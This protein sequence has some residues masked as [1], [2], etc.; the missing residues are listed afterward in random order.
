MSLSDS[1]VG[2]ALPDSPSDAS[3][4][5]VDSPTE[6]SALEH[7]IPTRLINDN[8]DD[9][10]NNLFYKNIISLQSQQKNNGRVHEIDSDGKL[11]LKISLKGLR[12]ERNKENTNN[13][14]LNQ[15][16][17]QNND[18]ISLPS[19]TQTSTQDTNKLI[20]QNAVPPTEPLSKSSHTSIYEGNDINTAHIVPLRTNL[21]DLNDSFSDDI[22][23][24]EIENAVVTP[25]INRTLNL[26][27]NVTVSIDDNS[28]FITLKFTPQ[29]RDR[30]KLENLSLLN[31]KT[32]NKISKRLQAKVKSMKP[33][34]KQKKRPKPQYSRYMIKM[35]E[36]QVLLGPSIETEVQ[37][38]QDDEIIEKCV[39]L[40]L[41]DPLSGLRMVTPLRSRFC[42]HVECF[43][44][45]S[46][47]A[48]YNLRP[49]K[50]AIQRYSEP[51][52]IGN[53]DVMRILEDTKRT[54]LDVKVHNSNTSSFPYKN[55]QKLL[56]EKNK[57]MNELEWFCCPICKL[58]FNIK[59]VGDVYVIGEF[60]DLLQDL[61]FEE[62][63]EY[64]EDIEIDM[65]EK[66]K[67]RWVREDENSEMF[68]GNNTDDAINTDNSAKD[69][70]INMQH[71]SFVPKEVHKNVE[72][73]TLDS[74]DEDDN[75]EVNDKIVQSDSVGKKDHE[76]SK[77][78]NS[79]EE[80]MREIDVLFEDELS[81]NNPEA[82]L[83]LKDTQ[84]STSYYGTYNNSSV[85][86]TLH[87]KQQ[88]PFPY[89]PLAPQTSSGPVILSSLFQQSNNNSFDLNGTFIKNANQYKG[90]VAF[91]P[92]TFTSYTKGGNDINNGVK[93]QGDNVPVFMNGEGAE[94][95]PIV[96]D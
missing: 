2:S 1:E 6:D 18:N 36:T 43:D 29:N 3:L 7:T 50:I 57:M 4:S 30:P 31:K 38:M 17:D 71:A 37:N 34:T 12:P 65:S 66:G 20:S 81:S 88:P 94:D 56:K 95:D 86:S 85:E 26:S 28:Y 24:S 13:T 93:S 58:E 35:P 61:T 55:K 80:M 16:P 59:R 11:K 45:E 67:W 41:K 69:S 72:V 46:F 68:N 5:N 49:F 76:I 52:T 89:A 74:E 64:V 8:D 40:S 77:F 96:I 75:V 91:R 60:I 23:W 21:E 15:H 9:N 22:S 79:E 78:D 53:V 25:N 83:P 42:S 39:R 70:T 14:N 73:V 87:K 62:N 27:K 48:M 63:N 32:D 10:N 90:V 92:G 54:V 33:K 51:A 47:L 19:A 44:Y 82:A 84:A